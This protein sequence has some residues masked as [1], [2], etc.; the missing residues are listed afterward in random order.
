MPKK[1]LVL[2]GTEKRA[3]ILGSDVERTSWRLRGLYCETWPMNH[4]VATVSDPGKLSI[5]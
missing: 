3:F 2:L 5:R 4:V 1:V